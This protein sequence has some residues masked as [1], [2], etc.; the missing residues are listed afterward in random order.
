MSRQTRF[1]TELALAIASGALFVLTLITREWVELIFRVDP[2]GG[3]GAL[4]WAIAAGLL[5]LTVVF[6]LLARAD[7]RRLQP[8][9]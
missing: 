5:A 8:A 7:H 4:E 3:S 9:A 1:R 6:S 2:D